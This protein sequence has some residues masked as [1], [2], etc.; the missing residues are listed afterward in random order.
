MRAGAYAMAQPE[1]ADRIGVG[2]S[3]PLHSG[4]LK[5]VFPLVVTLRA[6]DDLGRIWRD[7]TD[8]FRTQRAGRFTDRVAT[9][10]PIAGRPWAT[11]PHGLV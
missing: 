1:R 8:P 10:I 9:R 6:F 7:D 11:E 4:N 2:R 5:S 3:E